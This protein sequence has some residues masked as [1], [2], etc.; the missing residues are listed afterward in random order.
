MGCVPIKKVSHYDNR[1]SIQLF[2]GQFVKSL[3]KNIH[4]VY[5]LKEELGSGCY[6]RVVLG[7]NKKTKESRAIKIINKPSIQ[8]EKTRQKIMNE[9]EIQ[10]KLDHPNIIKLFEFYEDQFNLYLV[11][12][13]CTGGVLLE[14][15]ARIGCLTES[16]TAIY[17]KQILSALCYLNNMNIV[18]RDLKLENILIENEKSNCVKIADFG[19]A[20]ESRNGRKLRSLI[21]TVSYVAPEVLKKNYDFKC[22]V[23]SCGVIMHILLTGSLPFKAEN[24]KTTV[25]LILKS[26]FNPNDSSLTE[27]SESAKDLLI[28]MLDPYPTTR[29]S[30]EEAL[31]SSW[32]LKSSLPNIRPSLFKQTAENLKNFKETHKLQKAVIRYISSQVLSSNDKSQFVSIFRSLDTSGAGQLSKKDLLQSFKNLFGFSDSEVAEIMKRAD[33]DGNGFLD[34]TE[35]IAAAM[36]K[37]KLLSEEKLE[38]AFRA[39]DKDNNGKITACELKFALESKFDVEIGAYDILIAEVDS[40]RDGVID[41]SEFKEMMSRLVSD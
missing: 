29:I 2:T 37:K 34:Y 25:N 16:Q 28:K 39:F 3:E 5:E 30:C 38:A 14:Y 20:I 17:I 7:V 27:I 21:G 18:H 1:K 26:R 36:D 13:L 41:F 12:E 22:D 8:N 40:N 9:V 35:F 32:L 24:K 15:F 11:L 10:S 6:G 4:S 19:S 31:L 23:W 33:T